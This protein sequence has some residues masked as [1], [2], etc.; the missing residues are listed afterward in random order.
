[1][2]VVTLLTTMTKTMCY[3]VITSSQQTAQEIKTH[4]KYDVHGDGR[5]TMKHSQFPNNFNNA[6]SHYPPRR[7]LAIISH[8]LVV[9]MTTTNRY[10]CHRDMEH[11]LPMYGLE[12]RYH[13]GKQ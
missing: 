5:I 2:A 6:D 10:R 4:P 12:H 8:T 11:T 3:S 13:N 7:R 1:M 9:Y